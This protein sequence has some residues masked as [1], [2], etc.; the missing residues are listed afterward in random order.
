[1]HGEGGVWWKEGKGERPRRKK[2]HH[3]SHLVHAG[4]V[5]SPSVPS[6]SVPL[7]LRAGKVKSFETSSQVPSDSSPRVF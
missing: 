7:A 6:L 5:S 1:M 4:L 2:D 3:E